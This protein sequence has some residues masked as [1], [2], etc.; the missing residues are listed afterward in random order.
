MDVDSAGVQSFHIFQPFDIGTHLRP[1]DGG[2]GAAGELVL[3]PVDISR[4]I[5]S[6]CGDRALGKVAERKNIPVLFNKNG[7]GLEQSVSP[8]VKRSVI[9][10]RKTE[11]LYR[12][13]ATGLE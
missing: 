11:K 7:I 1:G 12:R 9:S 10:Y 8:P 2:K 3:G 13:S 5:G 6:V 4:Q